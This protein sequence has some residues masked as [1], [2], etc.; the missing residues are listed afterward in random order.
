[1]VNADYHCKRAL[2]PR[3]LILT[4]QCLF[5]IAFAA[6]NAIKVDYNCPTE[7]LI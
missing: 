7:S 3:G 6:E 1:V 4:L 2:V 5:V